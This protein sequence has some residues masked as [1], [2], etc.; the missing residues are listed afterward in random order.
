ML[1]SLFTLIIILSCN[2]EKHEKILKDYCI[3][4]IT[5]GPGVILLSESDFGFTKYLFESNSL[6][7]SNYQFYKLQTDVSGDHHVRCHQFKN[8]I[9]LFSNDLIFHFDEK[10]QYYRTSGDIVYEFDLDANTSMDQE[11]VSEIFTQLLIGDY[12]YQYTEEYL[13][14]CC[15]DVEFG[16]YDINSSTGSTEINIT[17]TWTVTFKEQKYPYAIIN[18]DSSEL[19]Y[20]D[21]GIRY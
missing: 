6:N 2:D 7:Y 10:D 9:R 17:K 3:E 4:D 20:Y 18:D 14:T 19:I 21:N 8:N 15:F 16:L 12:F 1:I 11:K 5:D 13:D